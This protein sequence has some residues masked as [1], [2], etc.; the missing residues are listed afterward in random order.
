MCQGDIAHLHFSSLRLPIFAYRIAATSAGYNSGDGNGWFISL[1]LAIRLIQ[2]GHSV[3]V[4][5]SLSD[6]FDV[7]LS[8]GSLAVFSGHLRHVHGDLADR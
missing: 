8:K 4:I 3:I 7:E 6:C 2:C 5:D 1:R